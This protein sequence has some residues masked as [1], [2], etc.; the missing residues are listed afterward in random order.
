MTS[1][2]RFLLLCVCGIAALPQ[3]QAEVTLQITSPGAKQVGDVWRVKAADN[4]AATSVT[5][6]VAA[7]QDMATVDAS[8]RNARH[9]DTKATPTGSGRTRTID[10]SVHPDDRNT[11]LELTVKATIKADSN[12][13]SEFATILIH[14][15][16]T[17]PIPL[18]PV[19]EKF[20]GGSATI[21]VPFVDADLAPDSLV[22]DNFRIFEE[23]TQASG[24][25]VFRRMFLAGDPVLS[26]DGRSVRLEIPNLNPG[27]HYLQIH[28][29]RD[30]V[31]NALGQADVAFSPVEDGKG[32]KR[33]FTVAG[34]QLR[35][36]QV[37]Y[38]R[39]LHVGGEKASNIDP[40]DRVDT[41]VVNLY[42]MRDARQVAEIINRNIQDLNQVGYDKAQQAAER[43]RG[44]A[45]DAVDQR[46]FRETQSVEA[47]IATRQTEARIRETQDKLAQAREQKNAATIQQKELD[48][49]I[50]STLDGQPAES[51]PAA[52]STTE[53]E[54]NNKKETLSS[55]KED[56]RKVSERLET[57]RNTPPVDG[58]EIDRQVKVARDLSSQIAD[59]QADIANST[60]KIS[61]LRALQAKKVVTDAAVATLST[62]VK[63]LGDQLAADK[64]PAQLQRQQEAEIRERN[65]VLQAEQRELRTSQEQFRQEVNAGLAD[66][67]S[68][69]MGKPESKDPVAQVT[70]SVVGTSRLQLRGPVKGLNKICRMIHQLDSP[71]G[72][73]KVGIHTVQLNGEHGDRMDFVYERINQDIAH[74]RFLVNASGQLLRRAVQ[75][76]ANEV[77]LAADQGYLPPDCPPE[78]TAGTATL[79]GTVQSTQDLRDRRY[80]YAFFGSDFISEL[81][82]MDSELLNTENKLLSL[83]SMDSISLAGAMFVLAHADH[84]VRQQILLRFQELIAGDLPM[85]EAEFVQSLTHVTRHGK[86]LDHRFRK[87][88]KIDE[89]QAAEIYFNAARTYHFP[90]TI[91]FFNNQ[92]STP[93][94]LNPVQQATLKMAQAL[95]AQ[96]TAEIEYTNFVAE[97]SLLET[98]DGEL[99]GEYTK[100]WNRAVTKRQQAEEALEILA[101]RAASICETLGSQL[102]EDGRDAG[103]QSLVR[104]GQIIRGELE[105]LD[106]I[107]FVDGIYRKL[108]EKKKIGGSYNE[109][110]LDDLGLY[111]EDAFSDGRGLGLNGGLG[112]YLP[113][114]PLEKLEAMRRQ[115]QSQR[116]VWAEA[117]TIEK[118]QFDLAESARKRVLSKRLL[119]Q[120]MDDQEEKSVELM[121]ALRSHASNVDNYLK[122]LA[123]A[124]DEDVAAQFYEPAFQ[125]IR[126]V[127]RTWDVT[128]SQIETTTV[129]TNNRTMALVS[130]AAS[131]EFNLPKRDI[132][133]KEAMDG[134]KALALEYGNLMKDGTFLAGTS[135]LAGTPPEGIV[136][137]N[138][139]IQGL[140]GLNNSQEFGSELQKLIPEPAI[141]KFETG[142]GFAVQP[143]I[144]PDGNSIIY[145]FDYTYTTQV[146]EP[147]RANEKHLGRVKRHFVRTDVQTSSYELREI[148][149]YT[150]ALKASR[151]DRGVPL[152]EDIPL[153][154]AAFRPLP[155]E[156]S[157]LQTNIILGS[158]TIYPTVYDLMGLRWSQHV[159]QMS[160]ESLKVQK[161]ELLQRRDHVRD[162]LIRTT[163]EEV[164]KS[165]GLETPASPDV[166]LILPDRQ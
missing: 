82:E 154:G 163:R 89:K 106:R 166:Q 113:G 155:S 10:A 160:S 15:D 145:G 9:G 42:Y 34:G 96:L 131:F 159:D 26:G 70:I 22:N 11:N 2:L 36:Q 134:A 105:T 144:Q 67:N 33:S 68:Y 88:M 32:V 146:R 1:R 64:L 75:E 94:T 130:P 156:E 60:G 62:D 120:F 158:S 72:Q 54:I 87:A 137:N 143:V 37:E 115:Y 133:I 100:Q 5:V 4:N 121:E 83:H 162:H 118:V 164:Y 66:R 39:F 73:V 127:S 14:V 128:L 95:K 104:A 80:L 86:S 74:S 65:Q 77:A 84:P 56:L 135:M 79:N 59:L 150:V 16:A 153:I 107:E 92:I 151:T 49:A 25:V 136:G 29:V 109:D 61:T 91:S 40:G 108:D 112:Q 53:N 52:I 101:A 31:G 149:R 129:L 43:A 114:E 103:L 28:S 50:V 44:L 46:R 142:T 45:N 152:F 76:V 157:S 141:Y 3:C 119:E 63:S 71:V 90:N 19:I 165:I 98:T 27:A 8:F 30:L 122:R 17:K 148:S 38:P 18:Q 85:R 13:T 55:K 126:R 78:L 12:T 6:A 99:E 111:I 117:K 58:A 7:L 51:L 116:T 132:L 21:V 102:E 139:P 161:Q 20:P 138:A 41:R 123:T 69:A 97:R 81:E 24:A 140:P 124:V 47:A 93:G 147:V 23:V 125:R 35:G 48:E 57:L 110:V